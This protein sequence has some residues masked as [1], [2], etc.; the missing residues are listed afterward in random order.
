MHSLGVGASR[1]ELALRESVGEDAGVVSRYSEECVAEL[2][3]GCRTANRRQALQAT[4]PPSVRAA[5]T[6][7]ES[8]Y[9]P[10]RFARRVNPY[11]EAHERGPRLDLPFSVERLDGV[12]FADE[13]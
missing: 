12:V 13:L 5:R 4:E 11:A 2:L 6:I 7:I 1:P 3:A 8:N 10:T 9:Y